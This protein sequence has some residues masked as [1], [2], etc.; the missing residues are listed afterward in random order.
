M[1]MSQETDGQMN[2]APSDEARLCRYLRSVWPSNLGREA[3]SN[4]L[5]LYRGI[6][7]IDAGSRGHPAPHADIP[8]SWLQW[9]QRGELVGVAGLSRS[10]TAHVLGLGQQTLYAWCAFDCMFLPALLGV[11]LMIR[12]QCPASGAQI[13]LRVSGD[14]VEH[15]SPAGTV[16]SFVT[17]DAAAVEQRL[18]EV[19][20]RHV[21]FFESED[22]ASSMLS[23]G[24]TLVTPAAAHRLGAVRNRIVFGDA[25]QPSS[26]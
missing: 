16:I 10:N 7:G 22:A 1:R 9:D 15:I 20:C 18:R 26:V 23:K 14:A 8:K 13:L 4:L 11:S 6:A 2:S 3:R 21:R 17:P 5:A 25:V 19:F 12:S 24:A